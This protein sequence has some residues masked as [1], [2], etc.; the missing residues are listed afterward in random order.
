MKDKSLRR[1]LGLLIALLIVV[2]GLAYWTVS[3]R[4]NEKRC[5]SDI[6]NTIEGSVEIDVTPEF[7]EKDLETEPMPDASD[8]VLNAETACVYRVDGKNGSGNLLYDKDADKRMIQAST[9]KLM[10]AILLVESGK[11]KDDSMIS[12]NAASTSQ[13]WDELEPG[14]VYSNYDLLYAMMLPSADDAAVAV[15]EGVAGKCSDFVDM[16]NKRASKLR[17]TNTHFI[18]PYGTDEDDHYSTAHDIARMTAYAYS[19]PD[20]RE[21]MATQFKTITGKN[22]GNTWDLESTTKILGYDDN[23]KGGKTGTMPIAG[24]CFAG[25]YE[26]EGK[27]YITVVLN[28]E[29]EEDR[30]AD[31]KRLHQF[32]RDTAVESDSSDES[33]SNTEDY[34]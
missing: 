32:I 30:W 31:T 33:D 18:N 21:A 11:L 28:C 4:V 17:M 19:F 9:T 24:F 7:S 10:T 6:T 16:M 15:A 14:D 22:T 23:F 27:T 34:T 20:I 13:F 26:Y 5:V 8:V 2:L 25:V 29:S 12:A 3:S 1:V